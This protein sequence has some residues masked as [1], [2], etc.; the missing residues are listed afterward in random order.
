MACLR[1]L[2]LALLVLIGPVFAAG[3]GDGYLVSGGLAFDYYRGALTYAWVSTAVRV[4]GNDYVWTSVDMSRNEA[5]LRPGYGRLLARS[6]RLVLVGVLDAGPAVARGEW[7]AAFGGGFMLG[8]S[9]YRGVYA[10]AGMRVVKSTVSG[11]VQPIFGMGV[12]K[13]F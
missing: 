1:V 2:S 3:D 13:S 7:G 12:G 6:G 8:W 11:G 5:S 4:T 10:G 9:V